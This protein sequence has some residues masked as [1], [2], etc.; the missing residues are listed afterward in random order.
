M[1]AVKFTDI[2]IKL[3][4][5]KRFI[6]E[7]SSFSEWASSNENYEGELKLRLEKLQQ[8]I[9]QIEETK[10]EGMSELE[11]LKAGLEEMSANYQVN[12]EEIETHLVE[13]L[14]SFD[15]STLVFAKKQQELRDE[16]DRAFALFQD[17]MLILRDEEKR[18][19]LAVEQAKEA[20]R[21][22]SKGLL[23]EQ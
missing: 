18:Q 5:Y 14:K 7:L 3:A 13:L 9:E 4:P 16:Y 6:D 8:E 11:S 2:V 10:K 23:A 19:V 15:E 17:R 12:K 22:I 1:D 20:F 21:Q